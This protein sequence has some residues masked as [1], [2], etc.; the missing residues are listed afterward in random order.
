MRLYATKASPNLTVMSLPNRESVTFSFFWDGDRAKG[1]QGNRCHL[2]APTGN[3]PGL[4]HVVWSDGRET[5]S[6]RIPLDA[7]D[8]VAAY[9]AVI[10]APGQPEAIVMTVINGVFNFVIPHA[11]AWLI[12]EPAGEASGPFAEVA[13][14]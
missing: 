7:L 13:S 8:G 6:P 12:A 10:D 1:W 14:V 5:R 3:R 9:S 4:L 2:Y 11:N